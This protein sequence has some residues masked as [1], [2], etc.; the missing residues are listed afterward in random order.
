[1]AERSIRRPT[2][3]RIGWWHAVINSEAMAFSFMLLLV[4]N[5]KDFHIRIYS[6]IVRR[7]ESAE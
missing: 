1:V 6:A 4:A 5:L 2:L 3:L 7:S